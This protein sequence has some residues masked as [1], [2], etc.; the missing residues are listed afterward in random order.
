MHGAATVART[1]DGTAGNDQLHTGHSGAE[2]NTTKG[3]DGASEVILAHGGDGKITAGFGDDDI[4]G[5][6]GNRFMR[7]GAGRDL[8]APHL[9][10]PPGGGKPSS[11]RTRRHAGFRET[12][13]A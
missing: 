6:S 9:R 4:H 3:S 12:Y 2:R 10:S 1:C 5:G 13:P 11:F 7:G 8:P